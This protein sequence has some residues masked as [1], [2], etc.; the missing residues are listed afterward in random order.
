MSRL[1]PGAVSSGYRWRDDPFRGWRLATYATLLLGSAVAWWF[2][3]ARTQGMD[4]S[5]GPGGP[6]FFMV[7]WVVMM[8]AMMFPSVAPMVATYVSVQRGRKARAMPAARAGSAFFV[9]GYLVA[10]SSAGLLCYVVLRAGQLVAGDSGFWQGDGRWVSA[11]VLALAAVY[12][13]TPAKYAC[14]RRCR[15]P[16]AFILEHWHDGRLGA[17]RMGVVHGLWC[18]GC[19]W[20]LMAALVALGLMSLGWMAVVAL[21]IAVEK[22]VPHPRWATGSVA[23][24]LA[25]A[26]VA[27]AVG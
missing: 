23:A 8:A 22:L 1:T 2:T 12:E 9:A 15:G 18:V 4:M 14:L 3:V 11:G 16:V 21:L 20:G 24:L 13:L 6:V 27:V 26:A 10:W 7:T 5:M 25:L 17:L 19:C